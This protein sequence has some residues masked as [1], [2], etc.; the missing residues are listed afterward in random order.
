MKKL[1]TTLSIAT[2]AALTLAPSAFAHRHA[3]HA[4][5][6]TNDVVIDARNNPVVTKTGDCVY[7]KW[8][9]NGP[10]CMHIG[11]TLEER[12][13]YFEFDKSRLTPAAQRKLD[14]LIGKIRHA[15]AVESVNIVGYA[16]RLG[17]DDYNTRLSHARAVTVEKYLSSKG[18]LRTRN[19]EVRALGESRPTTS[20]NQQ[21]RKE[22]IACLQ[23]DRRV[24][25]ELNL[26]K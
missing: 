22:L 26:M 18:H 5:S 20:C 7:T 4:S 3:G 2:V 16:D 9:G 10:K 15:K 8:Q 21:N 17:T 14:S 6:L 23:P 19:V 11:I 12:T 25:V 13:V 1:L 24:E